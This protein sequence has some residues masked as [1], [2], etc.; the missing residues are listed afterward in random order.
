MESIDSI[1]KYA[2]VINKDL[3]CKKEEIKYN[4]IIKQANLNVFNKITRINESKTLT[5]HTSCKCKVK[6]DGTK[7]NLDQWCND[8]KCQCECKKHYIYEK[9]YVSS[10][11]TCIFENRKYLVSLMDDSLIIC[12]EVIDADT[13]AKLNGTASLYEKT[14][15]NEKP[16]KRY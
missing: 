15:F 12:D 4:N 6:F 10:L 7:Y 9:D 8:D 16:V 14:T 11:C 5:K 1:E 13:E 2:Y 3:V